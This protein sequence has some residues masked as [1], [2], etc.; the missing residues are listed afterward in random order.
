[1]HIPAS[2]SLRHERVGWMRE[3]EVS[4]VVQEY[5]KTDEVEEMG[6]NEPIEAMS[7]PFPILSRA[8]EPTVVESFIQSAQLEPLSESLIEYV[9]LL[10]DSAMEGDWVEEMEDFDEE[11][12]DE[13]EKLLAE[14]LRVGVTAE[15]PRVLWRTV[16]KSAP[17]TLSEPEDSLKNM[18]LRDIS[19]RE[20]YG[21]SYLPSMEEV[22]DWSLKHVAFEDEETDVFSES[23]W[24]RYETSGGTS[25]RPLVVYQR[26][27][28]GFVTF[29]PSP[30]FGDEMEDASKEIVEGILGESDSV[31]SNL[32]AV[33]SSA[34][35][36]T[37]TSEF[38]EAYV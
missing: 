30:D 33:D 24:L 1:M 26:G 9:S 16:Y 3:E 17:R 35:S 7:R 19:G 32:V 14:S 5:V 27:D 29:S 25:E 37:R 20:R 22:E 31:E 2:D 8:K 6:A 13:E 11:E 38:L 21:F 15:V 28:S 23:L 4:M 34:L 12:L 18:P 36:G 10:Y